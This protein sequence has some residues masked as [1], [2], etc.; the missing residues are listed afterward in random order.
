MRR[1]IQK[2]HSERGLLT[3]TMN[4]EVGRYLYLTIHTQMKQ[5]PET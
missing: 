3:L 5:C 4:G 2:Q 1:K